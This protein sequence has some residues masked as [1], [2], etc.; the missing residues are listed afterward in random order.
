MKLQPLRDNYK[1]ELVRRLEEKLNILFQTH[2]LKQ[3]YYIVVDC[4]FKCK[5][6]QGIISMVNKEDDG[7]FTISVDYSEYDS[8]CTINDLDI[9]TLEYH[10]FNAFCGYE[11][12]ADGKQVLF[13]NQMIL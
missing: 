7:S 3:C 2:N 13:V 5:S 9:T 12:V 4:K 8:Q 1:K 6:I 10:V 11:E